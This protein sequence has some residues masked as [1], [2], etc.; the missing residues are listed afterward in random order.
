[1][2]L[3]FPTGSLAGLGEAL[4]ARIKLPTVSFDSSAIVEAAEQRH[5]RNVSRMRQRLAKSPSGPEF[6]SG[7][8]AVPPSPTAAEAVREI[9][10]LSVTGTVGLDQ[11]FH[12]ISRANS[13]TYTLTNLV[14]FVVF[15][16]FG[17]TYKRSHP[18]SKIPP[19][20]VD[21]PLRTESC[22]G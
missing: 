15:V 18:T 21:T 14:T 12:L 10:R 5:K 7:P 19:G 11:R 16:G 17:A 6:E 3:G 4:D 2:R 22:H 1:M 8:D 9:T 13:Y 20:P